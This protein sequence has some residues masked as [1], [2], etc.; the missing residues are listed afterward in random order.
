VNGGLRRPDFVD[1]L[2]TT[3]AALIAYRLGL[4]IPIPGIEP[5]ATAQLLLQG[6]TSA[7]RVSILALD[8][9]PLF[10]ILILAELAKMLVPRL[11]RWERA[12]ARNAAKLARIVLFVALASAVLQAS[13]LVT[14]LE[15]A[16]GVVADP[17]LMFRLST[18]LTL[19][20]G[21][22]LVSWLARQ[23][24][25]RGLGS[26]L[27]IILA[28][29]TLAALPSTLAALY[30]FQRQGIVAP[31]TALIGL[32]FFVAAIAVVVALLLAGAPSTER[33]RACAWSTVLA[34]SA[35]PFLLLPVSAL[36]HLTLPG[37]SLDWLEQG[38]PVRLLGLALLLWLFVALY[39]RSCRLADVEGPGLPSLLIAAVL[40]AVA[41]GCEVLPTYFG[42]PVILPG[43]PLLVVTLVVATLL[44]DW[45]GGPLPQEAV[46]DQSSGAN[47]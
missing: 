8:I 22:L 14:G 1:A 32:A 9:Y 2:L 6:G 25:S 34:Y 19:V 12:E 37:N 26:G 4:L 45:R 11:R 5:K 42:V 40:A 38:H 20:A 7:A 29:S 15:E 31:G 47:R 35:A 3:F 28:A 13:G 17:S 23:M 16:R 39:A 46:E 36:A 21:T 43:Q 30:E 41:L 10:G 18:T 44:R 33:A 27:W 24:S